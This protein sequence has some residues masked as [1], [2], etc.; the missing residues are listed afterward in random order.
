MV[1][2]TGKVDLRDDCKSLFAYDGNYS[3]AMGNIKGA[4]IAEIMLEFSNVLENINKS[5]EK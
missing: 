1:N 2:G 3:Q 4:F 5:L